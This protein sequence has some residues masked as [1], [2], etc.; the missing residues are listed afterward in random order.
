VSESTVTAI[1]MAGVVGA[2]GGGF[3]SHVKAAAS[4]DIILANGAECEPLLRADTE[5]MSLDAD[6]VVRGLSIVRDSVGASRA[7]IALKKK[8]ARALD[9]MKRALA[10]DDGMELLPLENVYPAG[11]EFLLV[12]EATGRVVP[13][14]G[15]PLDVGVVVNNVT[16]LAQVADA[17][18]GRPVGE[19]MVTVQGEVAEPATFVVPIGT[20]MSELIEAA[21]GA[22]C[23]EP[24]VVVGGPMMGHLMPA[25]GEPTT[26]TVAGAIVLPA[27]HPLVS[28]MSAR[29]SQVLRLAR[30]ACCQCMACTELCPRALLGHNL[31]PHRTVRAIQYSEIQ[32]DH[33][34]ITSAYLCCECGMCELFACPLGI[35]PRRILADLKAELARRGVPNPHLRTELSPD[36]VREYRQIPTSRLTRRL[37]LEKYDVKAPLRP[38]P[39]SPSRVTLRMKQ[40]VGLPAVPAVREEQEVLAGDVVGEAAES[41]VS[42]R[43]HASISGVI[44]SVSAEDIV[45]ASAGRTEGT[46]EPGGRGR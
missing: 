26:K 32:E 18:E 11:D 23:D 9:A 41:G 24:E 6:R 33:R 4:A 5:L 14:G 36:G 3:P 31:E 27:D 46:G 38:E 10:E 35:Q 1:Q 22:T 37:G 42:A 15:I 8:N 45:I 34:H 39:L 19:K 30:A 25:E 12:F 2:G 29:E 40:H 16:T 20:A 17:V 43:V 44:E 7:V 28:S 13:E 21:G